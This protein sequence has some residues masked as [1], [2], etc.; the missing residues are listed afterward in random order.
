MSTENQ[1]GFVPLQLD[2]K[3]KLRFRHRDLRDAVTQSG[4]SIGD[5]FLDPFG[6][7]P[8]LLLYGLRWQDMKLTLDKCS[9]FIDGWM[10]SHAE[11]ETPLDSLRDKLLDALNKSGFI[12]IQQ[13]DPDADP[14]NG[15]P[16]GNAT[17]EAAAI[18][19]DR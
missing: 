6:G 3:R 11:E 2:L 8:H 19:G 13:F 18:R 17:P 5:L 15:G 12:R 1:V 4:K 16:E 14:S 9:D 7:W 10:E